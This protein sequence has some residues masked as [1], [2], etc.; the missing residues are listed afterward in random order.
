MVA[1]FKLEGFYDY[2]SA[3]NGRGDLTGEIEVVDN[4]AFEGA[5]YDHGSMAPNQFVRGYLQNE[6]D[7]NKMIFLKF[8]SNI[9]L[10]N[11]A[12]SLDKE[13]NNS[14][15]GKYL[16]RWGALPFN[17]EFNEDAGLFIAKIDMSACGI[18]DS[19]E[20]NLSKK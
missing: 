3:P 18:G 17:T 6:G 7:L 9:N 2:V 15:E 12:Y 16:G 10:A 14:I 20:I 11:L 5:I 4:G 19:A 13:S 1:R 8:P